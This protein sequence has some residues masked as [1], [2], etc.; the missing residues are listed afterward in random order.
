MSLS[1]EPRGSFGLYENAR[2]LVSSNEIENRT[3]DYQ[4]NLKQRITLKSS[5]SVESVE[6]HKL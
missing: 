4:K 3:L 5:K 2:L 6:E 1:V